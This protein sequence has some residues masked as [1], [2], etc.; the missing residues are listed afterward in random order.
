MRGYP[1]LKAVASGVLAFLLWCG[2]AYLPFFFVSDPDAIIDLINRWFW[3]ALVIPSLLV[4]GGTAAAIAKDQWKVASTLTGAAGGALLLSVT[5]GSGD[6]WWMYPF[7][8]LCAGTV[9]FV[10][11]Y[12]ALRLLRYIRR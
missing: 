7:V 11:G 6:F 4:S 5:K 12:I 3:F 8:F 9:A 2:A 1:L 10:G